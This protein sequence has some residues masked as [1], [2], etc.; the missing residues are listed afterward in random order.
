MS[1]Y[2][3]AS[4][5][6][7]FFKGRE[8]RNSWEDRKRNQSREDKFDKLKFDQ[9][10]RL[11]EAHAWDRE[12]QNYTR[13]ER[14]R[15][16]ESDAYY[17]DLR[18]R[19]DA[20]MQADDEPLGAVAAST[21]GAAPAPSEAARGVAAQIGVDLGARPSAA[22]AMMER[23]MPAE[24]LGQI[25]AGAG[26]STVQGGPAADTLGAVRPT[27]APVAPPA[28]TKDQVAQQQA[29]AARR[30]RLAELTARIEQFEGIARAKPGQSVSPHAARAVRA[31]TEQLPSL[32]AERDQLAAAE[33]EARVAALPS[34]ADMRDRLRLQIE[35]R[36][37]ARKPN[38][39]HDFGRD[40]G[41]A[42]DIAEVGKRVPAVGDAAIGTVA[43][44]GYDALAGLATIP[45]ALIN[46]I[47]RYA[48]GADFGY[49]PAR[50]QDRPAVT[51][52]LGA[53][54]AQ[55]GVT[56]P[57]AA[58]TT[59]QVTG[60]PPPPLKETSPPVSQGAQRV[61]VSATGPGPRI[62]NLPEAK[63]PA[64][65]AETAA[66]NAL[67][68]EKAAALGVD[69]GAKALGAVT[70]EADR[71]E[72]V[73]T[74]VKSY[75]DRWLEKAYPVLLEGMLSRG[76][77][78]KAQKF[79]EFAESMEGRSYRKDHA[80][81]AYSLASGD[82]DGAMK[83]VIT[84]RNRLSGFSDG[85][86]VVED[87]TTFIDA[88]G[89]PVS[90]KDGDKV[91]GARV[92]VKDI[93]T[94]NTFEEVFGG[95]QTELAEMFFLMTD[96]EKAFESYIEAGKTARE[97]ALGAQKEAQAEA[98]ADE[99]KRRERISKR[100]DENMK[101]SMG[102]IGPDEA[103]RQAVEAERALEEAMSAQGSLGQLGAG[104]A[105]PPVWRP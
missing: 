28:I 9:A 29:D 16:A 55:K 69:D 60:Q 92:V 1:A 11:A 2:G 52:A 4:F 5:I 45:N 65:I 24:T 18:R 51:E 56:T 36:A 58:A 46:P 66:T 10:E 81:A 80:R 99:D 54:P 38:Y 85:L 83:H 63:R 20:A 26:Q 86:T 75:E 49:P 105:P 12:N 50:Q 53:A 15:A 89:N 91:A 44:L 74:A 13:G 27:A 73:E 103:M 8:I 23:T 22:D 93:R 57:P 17:E 39:Q 95:T 68:P 104:V 31:A 101:N 48:A 77:I 78:D 25:G 96:P 82:I 64:A 40:G 3:I 47:A 84:A 98:K 42:S 71:K 59:P 37:E 30:G 21:K 35:D 32:Y 61:Q 102:Q 19:A 97:G 94:G 6:D 76:D 14:S 67:G 87:G 88:E 90:A 62:A 7:G 100:A 33:N 43:G 70:P 34:E 41:L 79:M 72:R